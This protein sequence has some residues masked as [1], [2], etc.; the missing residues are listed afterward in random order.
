MF[1][2]I[3]HLRVSYTLAHCTM[4]IAKGL[5]IKE[6]LL[7]SIMNN[8]KGHASIQDGCMLWILMVKWYIHN[9]D[10]KCRKTMRIP[11]ICGTTF[12]HIGETCT[13]KF[14][15]DGFWCRLIFNHLTLA[16][17][18]RKVKWLKYRSHAIRNEQQTCSWSYILMCSSINVVA[19]SGLIYIQK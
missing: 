11:H 19:S 3:I 14:H 16:T 12:G 9:T 8:M 4:F 1:T 7:F 10:A 13:E 15:Y 6:Q 5:F 17:F 2:F 18:L